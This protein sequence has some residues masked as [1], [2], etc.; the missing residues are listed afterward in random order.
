MM[1]G[2]WLI[3]LLVLAPSVLAEEQGVAKKA[4]DG[5]K[6]GA[7]AAERG[8]KKG[9]ESTAKGLKKAGSWLDRQIKKI[10]K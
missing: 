4:G 7:E 5:V 8:I 6:K 1:R 3:A 10:Q 2:L 9:G